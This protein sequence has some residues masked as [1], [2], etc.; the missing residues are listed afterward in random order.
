MRR[1][2]TLPAVVLAATSWTA[3]RTDNAALLLYSCQSAAVFLLL[4]RS[5][6]TCLRQILGAH[7]IQRGDLLLGA[8][9]IVQNTL[10]LWWI[11]FARTRC[12]RRCIGTRGI[13]CLRAV[14]WCVGMRL[15][16][17]AVRAAAMA[18]YDDGSPPRGGAA[19]PWLRLFLVF[20]V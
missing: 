4:G 8:V 13:A 3:A 11:L 5:R 16:V 6:R 18:A 12:G 7:L 15:Y 19:A 1:E 20:V 10:C 9:A 17:C 2:W 14:H